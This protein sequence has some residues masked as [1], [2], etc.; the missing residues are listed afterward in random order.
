MNCPVWLAGGLA[1]FVRRLPQTI[2]KEIGK[3]GSPDDV[4]PVDVYLSSNRRIFIPPVVEQLMLCSW[5]WACGSSSLATWPC[6]ILS[7]TSSEYSAFI[8]FNSR[9]IG[10]LNISIKIKKKKDICKYINICM[11]DAN[12]GKVELTLRQ[13]SPY[14]VYETK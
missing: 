1:A 2:H 4:N 6:N 12:K 14:F 3:P 7:L 9:Q 11:P 5:L 10:W 8:L 13:E